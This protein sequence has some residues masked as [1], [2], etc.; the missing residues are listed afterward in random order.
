M[1]VH[2]AA[3]LLDKG[4]MVRYDQKT[5]DL[6]TTNLGRTSSYYYINFDT[7]EIFNEMINPSMSE[8]DIVAMMCF[9]SEF[10]QIQVLL[11][12]TFSFSSLIKAFRYDKKNWRI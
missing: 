1:H 2:H 4:H 11:T 3:T 12:I 8:A 9:A 5:G 7:M 6:M 10:Q